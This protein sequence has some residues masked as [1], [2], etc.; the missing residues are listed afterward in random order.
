MR[1]PKTRGPVSVFVPHAKN[2]SEALVTGA[3]LHCLLLLS[4]DS[5]HQLTPTLWSV[6]YKHFCAFGFLLNS[7]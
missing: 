1:A 3:F 6:M 4:I 7:S 5:S 2:F